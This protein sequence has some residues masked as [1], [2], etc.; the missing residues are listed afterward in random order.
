VDGQAGQVDGHWWTSRLGG[1]MGREAGGEGRWC[2]GT[3]RA[4]VQGGRPLLSALCS[5]RMAR[6]APA[7]VRG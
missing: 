7:L 6:A 2:Q 1:L 4:S 3:H 5:Q